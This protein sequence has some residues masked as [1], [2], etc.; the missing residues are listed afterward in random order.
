VVKSLGGF[1]CGPV[2]LVHTQKSQVLKKKNPR[3]MSHFGL[4]RLRIIVNGPASLRTKSA[5]TNGLFALVEYDS[6]CRAALKTFTPAPFGAIIA[7]M[8]PASFI[9]PCQV[10]V[11]RRGQKGF[12]NSSRVQSHRIR[13]PKGLQPRVSLF[14]RASM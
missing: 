3:E 2:V 11:G 13:I 6:R 8:S 14:V 1:V 5:R 10:V 7:D 9:F 12:A 4:P